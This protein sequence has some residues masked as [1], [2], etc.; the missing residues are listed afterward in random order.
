MKKW[1]IRI[2]LVILGPLI[3][4][5]LIEGIWHLIGDPRIAEYDASLE[6]TPKY[7]A[8]ARQGMVRGDPDAGVAFTLAP[9][10]EARVDGNLYRINEHGLRG[11]PI[12]LEKP[13][14]TKRI[15]VLGDSY[16]FG[17][18]VDEKDTI[19]AQLEVSI[20][21]KNPKVQVL[22]MGVPGYQTAQEEKVLRRDGLRFSP[23]V[24]V[25]VYYA[26]DNV[27][28]TFMWDPRIKCVYVDELPL[29]NGVRRFLARSILYSRLT[30]AYTKY[31]EHEGT[32]D[33][34]GERNWPATSSRLARIAALCKSKNIRLVMVAI[35]ALVSSTEFIE[36]NNKYNKD[37]DRV[38]AFA[39]Q[40]SIPVVDVRALILERAPKPI[41]DLFLE[42]KDNHFNREGYA[43]IVHALAALL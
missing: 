30:K 7:F 16:A 4:L 28:A 29:P 19:S 18:G 17:F 5:M 41:E 22:N 3:I 35:P 10:F 25:L 24:V 37:H 1:S 9:G 14:G 27:T 32:L 33:A 42:P 38:L 8:L 39:K 11:G 20:R 13:A 43:I 6:A 31:L 34:T 15:L 12:T 40:E 21:E 26:N 36:M 23:D 2:G